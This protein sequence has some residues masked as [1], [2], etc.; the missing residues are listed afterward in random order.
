M[1]KHRT[2]S[3]IGRLSVFVGAL[4]IL[5]DE[6][7]RGRMWHPFIWLILVLWAVLLPIV[8]MFTDES[9]GDLY[10]DLFISVNEGELF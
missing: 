9:L 10:R 7:Y 1:R 3:P 4:Y 2:L 5:K 6:T 8:A